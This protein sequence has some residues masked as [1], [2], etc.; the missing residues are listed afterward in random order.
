MNLIVDKESF[1]K[2]FWRGLV[3]LF[4]LKILSERDGST[5]DKMSFFSS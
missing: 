2:A 5:H 1:E 4:V 3:S